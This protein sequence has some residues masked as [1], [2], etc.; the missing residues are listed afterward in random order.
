MATVSMRTTQQSPRD[1]PPALRRSTGIVLVVAG[2]ILW[3]AVHV[4]LG[5]IAT[6]P[7]GLVL[8]LTGL[9]WLWIPVPAKRIRLRRR[10]NQ[11]MMYLDWDPAPPGDTRCSLD[12]LLSSRPRTDA[13]E[14]A[15]QPGQRQGP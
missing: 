4:R 8:L 1:Q 6:G 13:V 11:L 9:L 3:L 15:L 7:A 2:A 14:S 12:D 10:F 5:F